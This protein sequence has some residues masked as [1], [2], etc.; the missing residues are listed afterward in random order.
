M[1]DSATQGR[2]INRPV[3]AR[4]GARAGRG[5]RPASR[6]RRPPGGRRARTR[7]PSSAGRPPPPARAPDSA[8]GTRPPREAVG[9]REVP[10]H[11]PHVDR[12][13]PGT[14]AGPVHDAG[15]PPA[16]P[17]RVLRVAVATDEHGRAPAAA[18]QPPARSPA[19]TAR[20]Q[21]RRTSRCTAP[22]RS[23]TATRGSRSSRRASAAA[24]RRR[25]R[26]ARPPRRPSAGPAPATAPGAGRARRAGYEA[27]SP[28][29]LPP[30]F[31]PPALA[32]EYSAMKAS[33]AS[34]ALSSGR[35][36]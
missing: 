7:G 25:G 28:A 21:R 9:D 36:V 4:G 12:G 30:A 16:P 35:W 31:L 2:G 17:E 19:S 3:R 24:A 14:A 26:R 1:I 13:R 8:R 6:L 34:R 10:A 33:V 27:G 15:Q 32:R 18:R 5:R 23:A 22:S 29:F 11:V 20:A